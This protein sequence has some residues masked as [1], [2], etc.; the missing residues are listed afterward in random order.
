MSEENNL[1]EKKEEIIV[2]PVVVATEQKVE[3]KIKSGGFLNSGWWPFFSWLL[4]FGIFWGV[5]IYLKPVASDIVN[6]KALEIFTKYSQYVGVVF[7]LLS[8]V[9]IYILFGLKKLILKARLNFI[10]AII[11]ALAYLPWYLFARYLILYEK[12][13]TDI[14][15]GV[16][17]YV[18][19]PLK[20][21][22]LVVFVLAG[23]W[24][25]ISLLLNLKKSK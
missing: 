15:R 11:L 25:I 20:M 1:E 5:F 19:G 10:N 16:I 17:T 4:F 24:L 7:G 12:R 23:V 22:V 2:P 9:I 18:A 21:A 3:E 6:S 13:Y 8:M 14:G